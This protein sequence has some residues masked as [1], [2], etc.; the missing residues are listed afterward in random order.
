MRISVNPNILGKLTEI[1]FRR[2]TTVEK[3]QCLKLAIW[4]FTKNKQKQA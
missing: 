2:L 1:E 3:L 4:N